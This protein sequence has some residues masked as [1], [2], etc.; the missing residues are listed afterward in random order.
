MIIKTVKTGSIDKIDR[1]NRTFWKNIDPRD[2]VGAVE[3]Y[4]REYWGENYADKSGFPRVYK[5]IK[6]S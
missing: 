4:R 3:I 1:E 2:R 5:I 6:H